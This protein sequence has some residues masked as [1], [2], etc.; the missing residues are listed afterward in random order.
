[1]YHKPKALGKSEFRI[2][3][4]LI[5]NLNIHFTTWFEHFICFQWAFVD[6]NELRPSNEQ[7]VVFCFR[8]C[9]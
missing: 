1:M 4:V 6:F 9:F 8:Y 5:Y 2:L 7:Q 3:F